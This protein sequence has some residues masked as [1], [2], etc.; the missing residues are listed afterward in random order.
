MKDLL[1]RLPAKSVGRAIVL[2]R[3][4]SGGGWVQATEN[5][6]LRYSSTVKTF[7]G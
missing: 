6:G 7:W 2:C 5:D 3:L 4:P 1:P